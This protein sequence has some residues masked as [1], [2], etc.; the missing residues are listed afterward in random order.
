M[1]LAGDDDVAT[2]NI[3]WMFSVAIKDGKL[4][5]LKGLIEEMSDASRTN[6]PETLIYQWT[7]S[8]DEKTAEVHERYADSDA[9]LGHLA[10]FNENF[11]GRLMALVEPTGMTV[12]GSPSVALRKQLEGA[13]P[14]YRGVIGGF[15]RVDVR[16]SRDARSMT[17]APPSAD[18]GRPSGRG[19]GR[20]RRR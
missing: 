16:R 2:S 1:Q 3:F 15:A 18:T 14:V 19:A 6:E 13:E 11:A 10:S 8:D 12:Y 9:A 7:I 17:V 4:D 5:E 20:D